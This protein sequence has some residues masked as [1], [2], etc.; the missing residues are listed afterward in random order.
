MP[1]IKFVAAVLLLAGSLCSQEIPPGTAL[2]ITLAGDLTAKKAQSGQV[3]VANIAQSVPLP[4]RARIPAGSR[5]E[6]RVLQAITLSD[7]SSHMRIKFDRVR[8]ND[9]DI[10]IVATLRALAGPVEVR[11]A[12]LPKSSP[13]GGETPST[14]TT[15]Q[16]GGD[17][18]YRGGG[19]VVFHDKV[20]GDPVKDGVLAEITALPMSNCPQSSD[21]RRLALWIF[22]SSACGPY[23]FRFLTLENS[24]PVGEII[25]RSERNVNIPKG[26]AILLLVSEPPTRSDK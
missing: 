1:S 4:S 22:G 23:G 16:I 9:R 20:V 14:W 6:G 10:P 5:V 24:E 7:G 13:M 3:I 12:Q 2:P 21:G 19:H 25:L 11:N 15:T 26:S 17:D 8:V 18:V